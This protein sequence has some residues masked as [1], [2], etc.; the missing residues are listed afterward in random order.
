[1]T[2][3]AA[4]PV[5]DA[6][7]LLAYLGDESGAELVADQIAAGTTISTVNLAEALSTLAARGQDPA[8]VASELTA[9]GLLDGAITVEPF[10]TADAIEAARLRPLTRPAG[11][12]LADRACLALAR[13]LAIPVLTSDHAWTS[14]AL[15]VD[16]RPIRNAGQ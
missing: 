10:T 8:D 16:V 12:S 5:L 4:P 14:L 2:E 11:L 1:M 7:A 15:D 3:T 6:S 9:R 13:R